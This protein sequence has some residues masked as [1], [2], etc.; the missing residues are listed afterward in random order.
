MNLRKKWI[1]LPLDQRKILIPIAAMGMA[2]VIVNLLANYLFVKK[3]MM[4]WEGSMTAETTRFAFEALGFGFVTS[5]TF[6]VIIVLLFFGFFLALS[7]R[8]AGPVFQIQNRLRALRQ[9]GKFEEIKLRESDLFKEL[10][11]EVNHAVDYLKS[12]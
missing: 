5:L 6:N 10:A 9:S 3:V 8:I 4:S 12:R 7:N 11:D 2:V 1:V